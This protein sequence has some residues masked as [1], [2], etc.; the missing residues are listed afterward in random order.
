MLF[1]LALNRT[2]YRNFWKLSFW[3]V[4]KM[5]I[6]LLNFSTGSA[7]ELTLYDFLFLNAIYSPNNDNKHPSEKRNQHHS[8]Y[9]TAAD[10]FL[11]WGPILM[12]CLKFWLTIKFLGIIFAYKLSYENNSQL[13]RSAHPRYEYGHVT[14]T[15]AMQS[16]ALIVLSS[17][18][19]ITQSDTRNI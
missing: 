4:N 14:S 18:F 15:T 7:K 8:S 1:R 11:V 13:T 16:D 3:G 9:F 6:Q 17:V 19:V 12:T 10:V 2:I 5:S